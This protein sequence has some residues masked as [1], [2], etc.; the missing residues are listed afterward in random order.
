MTNVAGNGVQIQ[1]AAR[2]LIGGTNAAA[3]N[4]IAYRTTGGITIDGTNATGNAIVGNLIYSNGQLAFLTLAVDLNSDGV[5][6]NDNVPDT[7]NGPNRI[8]N[9]PVVTNAVTIVGS[10]RIQGRLD[11]AGSQ[12]YRIEF[13]AADA[14][15][16]EGRLFLGATNVTTAANGTG[17]FS[18]VL[19]SYA[20]TSRWITATATDSSNNTSEFSTPFKPAVAID[21]DNDKMPDFWESQYGLNPVVS[22]GPLADAD[23]DGYSD[24]SEY[25]AATIPN[26][27][28]SLLEI[29]AF[30]AGGTNIITFPTSPF[31]LYNLEA[32]QNIVTVTNWYVVVTNSL[33]NGLTEVLFDFSSPLAYRVRAIVP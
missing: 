14:N 28:S 11:S 13:F 27:S 25:L 15:F 30:S 33:G 4:I 18:V 10:T 3:G 31:R 7:D 29:T 32:A 1:N 12:T 21:L 24:Y 5:T 8:Q 17:A 23:G 22:N 2:N 16:Y 9:F 6:A 20:N 19:S 26:N